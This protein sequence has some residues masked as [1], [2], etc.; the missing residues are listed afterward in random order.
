MLL[1]QIILEHDTYILIVNINQCH[2]ATN[3]SL[4]NVEFRLLL[5]FN[6]TISIISTI[7]SWRLFSLSIC[8]RKQIK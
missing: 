7:Y 4:L 3:L 5:S 6:Y 1:I 8:K 2:M